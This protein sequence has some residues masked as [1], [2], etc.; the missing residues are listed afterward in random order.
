MGTNH[1]LPAPAHSVGSAESIAR[2][3]NGYGSKILHGFGASK[4]KLHIYVEIAPKFAKNT[5][6]YMIYI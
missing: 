3:V 4:W 5:D 1:T 2:H 6:F